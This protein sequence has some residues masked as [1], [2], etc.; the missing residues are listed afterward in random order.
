MNRAPVH[1]EHDAVAD[2]LGGGR[3]RVHG[4]GER[5]QTAVERLIALDCGER[6]ADA[7][8]DGREFLAVLDEPVERVGDEFD[9]VGETSGGS[10]AP[11]R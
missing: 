4:S 9:A 8:D 2:A 11:S 6:G 1:H 7:D 3:H 5:L 10:C